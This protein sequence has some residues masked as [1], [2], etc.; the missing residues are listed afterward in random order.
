MLK[1]V[2]RNFSIVTLA[3]LIEGG[4]TLFFVAFVARKLGPDLFGTYIFIMTAVMFFSIL[5]SAGLSPIAFRE[6]ARNRDNPG[7]MFE[8]IF[9]LRI[10]LGIIA[11][12]VM[13]TTVLFLDYPPDIVKF[14]SII[15]LSLIID[16]AKES[17]SAFH[18][19]FERLEFP[20][21][22]QLALTVFGATAGVAALLYDFGLLGVVVAL[23]SVNFIVAFIWGLIFRRKFLKFAFR[24]DVEGWKKFIRLVVPFA[25]IHAANEANNVLNPLLL[26]KITGPVPVTEAIGYFGPAKTLANIPVV[27]LVGMRRA[28]IPAMSAK[29]EKGHSIAAEFQAILK[30]VI[31]FICVPLV[32]V[33]TFYAHGLIVLIFGSNY[34]ESAPVLTI[35]GWASALQVAV[36]ILESLLFSHRKHDF[37]HYIP[38]SIISVLTNV[39]VSVL[40]IPI[41]S[42]TGAAIGALASRVVYLLFVLYYC[43]RKISGVSI[44]LESYWDVFALTIMVLGMAYVAHIYIEGVWQTAGVTF[45]AYAASTAVLLYLRR[46]FIRKVLAH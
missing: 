11:Y 19:A 18:T 32:L 34:A 21:I 22:F 1:S 7:P 4:I 29:L 30:A 45:V 24:V 36:M 17:F 16:A 23:L 8:Q 20:S 46:G 28:L 27:L 26:S 44:D 10:L 15:G 25:P 12:A 9:S 37:R 40:L 41:I 5:F 2:A 13:V 43:R 3:K 35:L 38:G 39:V 14:A 42:F 33:T 6:I 31:A